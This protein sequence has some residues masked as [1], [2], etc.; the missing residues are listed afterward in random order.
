MAAPDQ[1]MLTREGATF[2]VVTALGQLEITVCTPRIVRVRLVLD[3]QPQGPSYLEPHQWQPV[4][5]VVREGSPTLI[6]TGALCVR[7]DPQP[8]TLTFLR[9]RGH[10][11]PPGT[12]RRR[13]E[14]RDVPD[15]AGRSPARAG[16]G[17]HRTAAHLGTLHLDW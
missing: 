3:G 8:L 5:L 10:A 9:C 7:I 4:E 12:D 14:R 2:S 1:A 17:G 11:A 13:G 6:E 15:H 16:A